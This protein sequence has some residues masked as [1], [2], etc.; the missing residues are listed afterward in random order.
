MPG[1]SSRP[2]GTSRQDRLRP[3]RNLPTALLPWRAAC[4]RHGAASPPR[5]LLAVAEGSLMRLRII[6]TLAVLCLT[7]LALASNAAAGDFADEPCSTAVGDNFICPTATAGAPY[8]IDIKLKEPWPGCTSMAVS[9]GV[10]PPGLSLAS[11]GNITGTPTAA[12]SYSFFITVTWS[13][14]APCISQP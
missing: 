12:G 1:T 7:G 10:F 9:S 6:V 5:K 4:D 2:L 13:N 3:L 8:A 14:Q 11:E